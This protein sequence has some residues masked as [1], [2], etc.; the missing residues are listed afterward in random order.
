LGKTCQYLLSFVRKIQ[1]YIENVNILEKKPIRVDFK[2]SRLALLIRRALSLIAESKT[3]S[4]L[5]WQLINRL[6]R[7]ISIDSEFFQVIA[8]DSNKTEVYQVPN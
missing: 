8:D 4:L 6:N 3:T 7:E 5:T 1:E 2:G